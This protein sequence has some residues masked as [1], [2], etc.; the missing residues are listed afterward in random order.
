MATHAPITIDTIL[1]ADPCDD[2]DRDRLEELFDGRAEFTAR[3]V[4]AADISAEDR[5]W[6]LIYVALNDRQRR[7]FAADCAERALLRER[8]A[9]HEPDPRSWRAVE[10]ARRFA[11]GNATA[12]E[13]SAAWAAARDAARAAARDA[14][15]DAARDAARESARAATDPAWESARAKQSRRLGRMLADGRPR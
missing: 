1:A 8:E 10:V 6:V 5:L 15:W 2:Y 4:A 11:N 9:G 7:L 13:L 12:E 14:A 3:Q